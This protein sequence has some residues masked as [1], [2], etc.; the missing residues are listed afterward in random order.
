MLIEDLLRAADT[1][2]YHA[3]TKG[4]NRVEHAP[5]IQKASLSRVATP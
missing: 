2:L 4:R 3:K 1:A 5:E